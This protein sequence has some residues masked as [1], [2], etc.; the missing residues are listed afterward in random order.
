MSRIFLKQVIVKSYLV[1]FSL[2]L[3]AFELGCTPPPS[4][5]PVS[6]ESN[7]VLIQVLVRDEGTQLP[8]KDAQ[9]RLLIAGQTFPVKLSD[10]YGMV[11]FNV[12]EELLDKIAE[13]EAIKPDYEIEKQSVTLDNAARVDIY[14]SSKDSSNTPSVEVVPLPTEQPTLPSTSTPNPT[15]TAT[16]TNTSTPTSMP[17]NTPTPTLSATPTNTPLPPSPVNIFTLMRIEGAQT[18]F[19]LG[20]PDVSNQQ[21]GTL[22]VDETA[23]I[24]GRTEQYEWLQIITARGVKGW[25]A[26]CEVV[27][28]SDNL[29]SVPIAWDGS[30][31]AKN[32]LTGS[33]E[34]STLNSGSCVNVILTRTDWP[35]KEF[36]DVLLTWSNVPANATR[37]KLWVE[38][39]TNDGVTA[40]VIHPTFSDT[41]TPYKVE[42]FKFEDGD[43]KPGVPYTYVVQPLN[44]A[45]G[46]ICTR[47]ETF[48]P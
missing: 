4:G 44:A 12:D 26:N 7:K 14:M 18:V 43:F 5:T 13:F 20:G 25:V 36:D 16:P 10:E 37:L 17:T 24:I 2:I 21:L 15:E 48:V 40:Y 27:L 22:G 8:L 19:V 42:L 28:S 3:L 38:G 47:E 45:G 23:E 46:V 41:Q 31:T 32:C 34:T 11:T 6:V 39:P 1:I 29:D 9:V 30:V 33:S 35:S